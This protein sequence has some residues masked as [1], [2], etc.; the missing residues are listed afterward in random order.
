MEAPELGSFKTRNHDRFSDR[1]GLLLG[2]HSLRHGSCGMQDRWA[3]IQCQVA[4]THH[5]SPVFFASCLT[6]KERHGFL[7]HTYYHGRFYM[8]VTD[9][10]VG[11]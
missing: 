2:H 11:I 1:R 8:Y 10:W 6:E 9:V 7:S 3:K 4:L 5:V